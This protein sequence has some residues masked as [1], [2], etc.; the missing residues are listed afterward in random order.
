MPSPPPPLQ[1]PL[2]VSPLHLSPIQ[3]AGLAITALAASAAPP[4]AAIVPRKRRRRAPASGAADDCF[5]CRKRGQKCDRRRPYCSQCLERGKECSGYKTQLTWGVGVASR[6]KLRGL[7]TPVARPTPPPPTTAASKDS[8]SSPTTNAAKSNRAAATAAA[9]VAA[10]AASKNTPKAA[11]LPPMSPMKRKTTLSMVYEASL[12]PTSAS[13]LSSSL[14]L[15][16]SPQLH[17]Q[18]QQRHTR[19]D[20]INID[21]TLPPSTTTS[22]TTASAPLQPLCTTIHNWPTPSSPYHHLLRHADSAPDLTDTRYNL[23][24]SLHRLQT[25]AASPLDDMC[26]SAAASSPSSSWSD[27]GYPSPTDYPP[28]PEDLTYLPTPPLYDDLFY[29]PPAYD[30]LS[31]DPRGPTSYPEL[32]LPRTAGAN[33]GPADPALYAFLDAPAEPLPACHAFGA[34]GGL[35][36]LFYDDQIPGAAPWTRLDFCDAF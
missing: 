28:T 16:G 25:P 9:A 11:S 21:P 5:A 27:A 19:Y 14:P 2:H 34:Q 15:A 10:I 12:P 4:P 3:P 30:L 22:T 13:L 20:F 33:S 35:S 18:Q 1:I 8:T 36:D 32:Y 31:F 6:G 24:Q 26:F 23:R 7:S 29:A 17:Q